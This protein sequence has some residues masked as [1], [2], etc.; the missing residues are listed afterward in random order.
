LGSEALVGDVGDRLA[1][2]DDGWYASYPRPVTRHSDQ[3]ERRIGGLLPEDALGHQIP[4]VVWC[5]WPGLKVL[6]IDITIYALQPV[7][8]RDVRHAS[9]LPASLV[10][11]VG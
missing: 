2:I 7:Q 1:F 6:Q 10:Q 9:N 8:V 3:G 4:G 11:L 5:S